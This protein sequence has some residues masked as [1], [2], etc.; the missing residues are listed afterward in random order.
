MLGCLI[1]PRTTAVVV[2]DIIAARAAGREL[3]EN[4]LAARDAGSL[5]QVIFTDPQVA[6]GGAH[7]KSGPSRRV[8]GT[9]ANCPLPRRSGIPR[10]LQ[11]RLRRMGEIGH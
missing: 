3:W 4:E 10:P 1:S 9:D 7:G 5:A 11:G 8:R 2:A 6:E